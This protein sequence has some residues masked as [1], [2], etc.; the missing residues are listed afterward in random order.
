MVEDGQ[1]VRAKE[2][3]FGHG[4]RPTVGQ[5]QAL[6]VARGLVTA[7]A[8]RPTVKPGNATD[9]RC[10]LPGDSPQGGQGV[11]VAEV[12]SLRLEADERVPGQAFAALD[13]LEEEAGSPRRA[14][15]RVG[16]HGGEHVGKHL[17]IKRDELVVG[18]QGAGLV[19]IGCVR[20][21]S[22]LYAGGWTPSV[23]RGR[24]GWR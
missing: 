10:R 1:V 8:D 6:E 12:Q 5:G 24:S 14:Q 11:A 9:R 16:A 22:S 19:A 13:A 20:H 4:W 3:A 18:G 7:I 17:P 15:E 23:R 21:A 2:G